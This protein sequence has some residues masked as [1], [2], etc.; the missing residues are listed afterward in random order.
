MRGKLAVVDNSKCQGHGDCVAACP[1]GAISVNAGSAANRFCETHQVPL[2]RVI[3]A[4]GML[5]FSLIETLPW[6][7][8]VFAGELAGR[9]LRVAAYTEKR[10]A[11]A[12]AS[13]EKM[14]SRWSHKR[15]AVFAEPP[16][17]AGICAML[18]LLATGVLPQKGFVRQEEVSLATFLSNRFGCA[19]GG[20][21]PRPAS[22]AA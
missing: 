16:L 6:G 2:R 3:T 14:Y 21:G 7:S 8:P 5:G 9:R 12:R 10:E 19:Y 11:R 13:V 22:R 18:D 15:V 20:P 4:L 17:A 1:V